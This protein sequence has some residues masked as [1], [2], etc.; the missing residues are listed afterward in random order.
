MQAFRLRLRTVSKSD[1]QTVRLSLA[2]LR[3]AQPLP[4]YEAPN[5]IYDT[6]KYFLHLSSHCHDLKGW[7]RCSA[8]T[9][10][11]D[12]TD[13]TVYETIKI[14]LI[15]FARNVSLKFRGQSRK[16]CDRDDIPH[17]KFLL[18]VPTSSTTQQYC[19]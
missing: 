12:L 7:F 1:A 6:Q 5:Y 15:I 8:P 19:L 3:D 18:Y 14:K 13:S 11:W 9:L 4:F 17:E 10:A 2:F 16:S